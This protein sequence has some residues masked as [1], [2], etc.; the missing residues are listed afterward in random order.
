MIEKNKCP[1]QG[2]EHLFYVL[3]I[4]DLEEVSQWNLPSV[5]LSVSNLL[6][7]L[8]NALKL[9]SCTQSNV[10]VQFGLQLAQYGSTDTDVSTEGCRKLMKKLK[11]K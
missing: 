8:V 5:E 3:W 10:E 6:D 1:T 9:T 11:K 2:V 4:D 7:S